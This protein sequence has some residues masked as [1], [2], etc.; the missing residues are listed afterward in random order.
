MQCYGFVMLRK[1]HSLVSASPSFATK[2]TGRSECSANAHNPW[3]T[4]CR[5]QPLCPAAC[6]QTGTRHTLSGTRPP[7][8]WPPPALQTWT[9]PSPMCHWSWKGRCTACSTVPR[10]RSVSLP[11]SCVDTLLYFSLSCMHT[12]THNQTSNTA[13]EQRQVFSELNRAIYPQRTI[14]WSQTGGDCKVTVETGE[15][16]QR[17]EALRRDFHWLFSIISP[18]ELDERSTHYRQTTNNI[19]T[20][21]DRASQVRLSSSLIYLAPEVH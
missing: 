1:K 8:S 2:V 5:C 7:G 16:G 10:I 12:H 18:F 15:K 11:A 21:I 13:F 3:L 4:L 19:H 6:W 9:P 14:S 17:G 20:S